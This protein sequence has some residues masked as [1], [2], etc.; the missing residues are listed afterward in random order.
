MTLGLVAERNLTCMTARPISR[1]FRFEYAAKSQIFIRSSAG[2]LANIVNSVNGGLSVI[3]RGC[4]KVSRRAEM[5]TIA[6][7]IAARMR[8]PRK[9]VAKTTVGEAII[10]VSVERGVYRRVSL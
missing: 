1:G 10:V 9:M 5:R 7:M 4:N 3:F 8:M 2:R 6:M